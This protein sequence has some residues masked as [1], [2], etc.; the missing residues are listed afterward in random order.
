MNV[1][2]FLSG[3]SEHVGTSRITCSPTS[4]LSMLRHRLK[5][6]KAT[7]DHAN[8]EISELEAR[9]EKLLKGEK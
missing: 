1:G 7:R 5:N 8:F 6:A 3:E 4:E 2:K 9:I